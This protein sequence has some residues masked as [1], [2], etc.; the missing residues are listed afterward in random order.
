MTEFVKN[1]D[2]RA[3]KYQHL[4]VIYQPPDVNLNQGL[5][6]LLSLFVQA[7]FFNEHFNLD[8][9]TIDDV[10][11]EV[12]LLERS[13]LGQLGLR[14]SS[15]SPAKIFSMLQIGIEITISPLRY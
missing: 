15:T 5:C 10:E 1:A 6:I 9:I 3:G 13:A 14:K 11:P 4:T 12:S 2:E 7:N 8:L